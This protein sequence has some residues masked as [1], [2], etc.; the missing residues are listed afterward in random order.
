MVI[1]AAV[2]G[3][4][5]HDLVQEG[6]RHSQAGVFP[7]LLGDG[8]GLPEVEVLKLRLLYPPPPTSTPSDIPIS[9][10]VRIFIARL[11]MC[12]I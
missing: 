3:D 12:Y 8:L 5:G 9:L 11:H 7:S 4:H 2:F 1:L 6:P 10:Q